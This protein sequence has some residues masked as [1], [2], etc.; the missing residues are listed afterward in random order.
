[1]AARTGDLPRRECPKHPTAPDGARGLGGHVRH[2]D[3]SSSDRPTGWRPHRL[4]VLSGAA[5]LDF[6]SAMPLDGATLVPVARMD[7]LGARAVMAWPAP[8]GSL[9]SHRAYAGPPAIG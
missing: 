2:R 9:R 5:S 1:M 7:C 8:S 4:R 3:E 6:Q